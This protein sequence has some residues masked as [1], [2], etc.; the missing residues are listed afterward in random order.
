MP[1]LTVRENLIRVLNHQIPEWIPNVRQD[2]CDYLPPEIAERAPGDG[3]PEQRLGGTGF[4]WFGVHWTFQADIRASMVSHEYP[5]LLTDVTKWKEVV[6]FPDL[7]AIDWQTAAERD[8][9]RFQRDKLCSITLLNGMFERLHSLMGMTEACCALMLEPEAVYAFF[10]AVAD[11]KI[12]LMEKIVEHYQVD[13]IELHDDWGF[14]N[15]SFFDHNTWNS[16]IRPHIE[17]IVACGRKLGIFLRFH[18]CGKIDNLIP[19][20]VEA[21]IEHWSSAQTIND[22]EMIVREFGSRLVITGAMDLDVLKEPGITKE[23]M[24]TIVI[25]Q[26]RKLGGRGSVLPAAAS[27]VPGVAEVINEVLAEQTDFITGQT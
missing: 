7:D 10:E 17:R 25:G 21:G 3:S 11:H 1:K 14:Q 22:L 19:Y 8:K 5:P 15:N 16:L 9:G 27:S 2:S 18:S 12:R 4:D 20:M 24:K 13:L 6:K 23:E 26:I